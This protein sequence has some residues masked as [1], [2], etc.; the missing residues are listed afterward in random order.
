MLAHLQNG[1][2]AEVLDSERFTT[3]YNE[4]AE[5][6]SSAKR[7]RTATV[8]AACSSVLLHKCKCTQSTSA[9]V[10]SCSATANRVQHRKSERASL[11]LPI[12]IGIHEKL[13]LF[14]LEGGYVQPVKPHALLLH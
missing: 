14:D 11:L 8:W 1:Y 2:I 7:P 12:T 9:E 4:L 10:D 13:L 6:L 3:R 5:M